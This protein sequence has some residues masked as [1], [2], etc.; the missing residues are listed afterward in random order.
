MRRF[1]RIPS[2]EDGP[3]TCDTVIVG[4]FADAVS[5]GVVHAVCAKRIL[6]QTKAI[7]VVVYGYFSGF[8][9]SLS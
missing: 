3:L 2:F 1:R 4:F 5:S 7:F 6:V 8:A 9:L